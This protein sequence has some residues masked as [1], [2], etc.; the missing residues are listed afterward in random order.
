MSFVRVMRI[1]A[2]LAVLALACG[3]VTF[4][5]SSAIGGPTIPEY[6]SFWRQASGAENH[7]MIGLGE[8]T[9]VKY[10]WFPLRMHR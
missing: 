5:S 3:Q 4:A 6:V 1:I 2:G 8:E 7:P 10:L 9:H